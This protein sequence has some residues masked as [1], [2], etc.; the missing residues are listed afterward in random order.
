MGLGFSGDD[1][2]IKIGLDMDDLKADLAK[3][4]SIVT[5]SFEKMENEAN[6]NA[7]QMRD[8]F[9]DAFE[10]MEDDAKGSTA[11]INSRLDTVSKKIT[12]GFGRALR[13]MGTMMA[14]A[15]SVHKVTQFTKGVIEAAAD[16]EAME[17]AFE[18]VFVDKT[19]NHMDKAT[20]NMEKMCKEWDMELNTLKG[21]YTSFASQF[22]GLGMDMGESMEASNKALTL[23]ADAAAMFNM[24]MDEAIEKVRSFTKGNYIGGESIQLFGSQT[25]LATYA[26]EQGIISETAAFKELT[27]AEKQNIRLDYATNQY[28]LAGVTGQAARESQ[29]Y[30]NQLTK[31]KRVW[32]DFKAKLGTKALN[33]VSGAFKDISESIKSIDV[34]A[35]GTLF[36][37]AISAGGEALGDALEKVSN[38]INSVNWELFAIQLGDIF[39]CVKDFAEG[40]LVGFAESMEPVAD[41]IINIFEALTGADD[42]NTENMDSTNAALAKLQPTFEWLAN[43]GESVGTGIAAITKALAAWKVFKIACDI[44]KTMRDIGKDGIWQWLDDYLKMGGQLVKAAGSAA[45]ITAG[46]VLTVYLAKKLQ[47]K[48]GNKE[49]ENTKENRV[50]RASGKGDGGKGVNLNDGKNYNWDKTKESYEGHEMNGGEN[51]DWKKFG[52]GFGKVF[53]KN[54]KRNMGKVDKSKESY[55]WSKLGKGKGE[56]IFGGKNYDWSKLG[57]GKGKATMGGKNY[58]W[59]D[60]GKW[61]KELLSPPK[62]EKKHAERRRG[63]YNDNTRTWAQGKVS[64]AGE[65]SLVDSLKGLFGG[66][67]NKRTIDFGV[68]PKKEE[69]KTTTKQPAS[70]GNIPAPAMLQGGK[71]DVKKQSMFGVDFDWSKVKK[72]TGE[73][74]NWCSTTW[75]GV[76]TDAGTKWEG[77]KNTI[78]TKT[79]N[80]KKTVGEKW[81]TVKKTTSTKWTELKNEAGTKWE[82]IKSTVATKTE[83]AKKTVGEK[84][85]SVKT[86]ATTKWQEMKD[87][88]GTKWEGIK[89]TISTKTENAKKTVGTKWSNMKSTATTKWQEMKDTA[90]T[91][92]EGIKTTMTSKTETAKKT[93]STKWGDI[94]STASTKWGEIKEKISGKMEDI[95]KGAEKLPGKIKSAFIKGKNK[96]TEGFKTMFNTGLQKIE[97]GLN[98]LIDAA[99]NLWEK[100]GGKKNK[101]GH[102]NIPQLGKGTNNWGGG[103]AIVGE[104]G[105]ELVNDPNMGT[106]MV[107]Q[108]TLL[109]LSKGAMVLRNSK[110]EALLRTLGVPAYGKGKNEG[111]ILSKVGGWLKSAWSGIKSAGKTVW[112]YMTDPSKLFDKLFSIIKVDGATGMFKGLFSAMK[113]KF[114]SRITDWISNAFDESVPDTG[115]IASVEGWR[116][117]VHKAAAFFG[118]TLTKNEVDR[119]LQQIRTES[120]GNQ[121]IRQSAAVNDENAKS[122]NWARGL[123]QY[124]PSTFASYKVKGF[125]NIHNGY[126]QLLAFFNN[127]T[128]RKALPKLGEIRGWTPR[129][130]RRKAANGILV[131]GATPLTVGEKGQEAVVPLSNARALK[132][133]GQ[134][135]LNAIQEEANNVGGGGVYEFTIPVNIDG[136]QVAI[137]TATFTKEELDKLEKR[138]NRR[139]GV[140]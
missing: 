122:G 17:A 109:P 119:V 124:V 77:V 53:G 68:S 82:G 136:R 101:F 33:G 93:L 104:R 9:D 54:N 29:M 50:H 46:I 6:E 140:R 72:K 133:F 43:N 10:R 30:A 32:E 11:T 92:W 139:N 127:S 19:G 64:R 114:K 35:L 96:I 98:G 27:E 66:K 94:K 65:G 31:L 70:R 42:I 78:S 24:P 111:G 74:K 132:P 102:V 56:V 4:Q 81:S 107:N 67:G 112:D 22:K 14:T 126:H 18:Q 99:N 100:L 135:V 130:S 95:K 108:A 13:G 120:G 62:G 47:D 55:D 26:V 88:A 41:I 79:E 87:T 7:K 45:A 39:G 90:G 36:S 34:D 103:A 86:T 38:W 16:L 80:A 44:D 58:D 51:F 113:D 123:L 106:F 59:S 76:K 8:H 3:V 128:W 116:P 61:W 15:F 57:K 91:K 21:D 89:S 85:T 73:M 105:R 12:G 69:K 117:L 49:D 37:K 125:G 131:D 25:M 5:S 138:E 115:S 118:D 83:N 48:T 121:T 23:A 63:I 97:D 75:E 84:W 28:K 52:E 20:K 40:V 137:A 60:T 129:G 1:I 110:T 71:G 2:I 134:S